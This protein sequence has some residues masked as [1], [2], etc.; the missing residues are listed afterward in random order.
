[1]IQLDPNFIGQINEKNK[2]FDV[3]C[4]SVFVNWNLYA[5]LMGLWFCPKDDSNLFNQ[6]SVN[7]FLNCEYLT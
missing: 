2:F 4:G 7:L 3:C 6:C 5:G 1:M